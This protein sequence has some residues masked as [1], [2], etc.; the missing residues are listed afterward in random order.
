[1]VKNLLCALQLEGANMHRTTIRDT[2][3]VPIHAVLVF[4]CEHHVAPL[5]TRKQALTSKR[6]HTLSEINSV[7]SVETCLGIQNSIPFTQKELISR[8][9]SLSTL[10]LMGDILCSKMQPVP[11]QGIHNIFATSL[12]NER[13]LGALLCT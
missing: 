3:L 5:V 8:H 2:Q 7:N 11:S 10:P 4:S 1:M 6:L 9:P 12:Q 13:H